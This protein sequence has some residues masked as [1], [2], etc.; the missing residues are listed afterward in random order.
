M[1]L[2]Q[3][4]PQ[5][6]PHFFYF[7]SKIIFWHDKFTTMAMTRMALPLLNPVS[8]ATS[9]SSSSSPIGRRL[10]VPRPLRPRPRAPPATCGQAG[11]YRIYI[12][13]RCIAVADILDCPELGLYRLH[14]LGVYPSM[15]AG[16]GYHQGLVCCIRPFVHMWRKS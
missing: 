5:T 13:K 16:V 2:E 3:H 11:R 8:S 12:W 15:Y 9:G 1:K 4:T 6:P 10:R 7:F 14:Y